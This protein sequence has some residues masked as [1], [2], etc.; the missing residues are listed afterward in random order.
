M[1]KRG[2]IL[3][4]V[5]IF[6]VAGGAL[7][8]RTL[9][10]PSDRTGAYEFSIQTRFVGSQEFDRQNG[11]HLSLEDNLGWGFGVA[12][13]LT[14]RFNVGLFA[15]WR[16][17]DYS[18][19]VVITDPPKTVDFTGWMDTG[20]VGVNATLNVFKRRFTPYLQGAIGWAML[21]T[22]IPA[23]S[24]IDMDCFWDPWWG[25]ICVESGENIGEDA[26]SY[27]LGGGLSLQLTDEFFVRAGYEKNWINVEG[28]DN[29]DIV[30]VDAGF[31]Y[32]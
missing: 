7:G 32:R 11:S 10:A 31:L 5:L 22:N 20:N 2:V 12:Y 30:R 26:A 28:A 9:F 19:H 8:Q 3:A 16:S 1:V 27:M 13:H 21:D 29:F 24:G 25:T 4:S 17:I 14:E 18:A 23:L 6:V 15:A